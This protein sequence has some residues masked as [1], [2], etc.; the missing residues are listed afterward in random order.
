[1]INPATGWFE[2][3]ALKHGASA[4]KAQRLLD[5][6]CLA[7][8]QRPKEIG[9]DG[10]SEFKAEFLELCANMGIKIIP[11]GAWNPQSNL[12]LERLYQVL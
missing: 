7:R 2:V 12:V 5:S 6:Q 10:G 11:S 9:F 4:L 3:A 1:M 8:H